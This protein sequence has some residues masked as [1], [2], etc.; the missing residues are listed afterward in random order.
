MTEDEQGADHVWI[1][2]LERGVDTKLTETG[3]NR[4]PTWAQDGSSITFT[5]RSTDGTQ[6]WSRPADLS[7]PAEPLDKTEGRSVAGAWTPDERTL[8]YDV[9]GAEGRDIWS[10]TISGEPEP[11]LATTFNERTPRLSPDGPSSRHSASR[12]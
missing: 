6:L 10:L 11:F 12:P 2:D 3:V 4:D 8:V 5:R 1:R 9:A 7:G